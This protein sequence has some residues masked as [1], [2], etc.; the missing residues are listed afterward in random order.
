MIRSL[1]SSAAPPTTCAAQ[2]FS[3]DAADAAAGDDI[4]AGQRCK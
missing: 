2:R 3:G 1:R 4:Q